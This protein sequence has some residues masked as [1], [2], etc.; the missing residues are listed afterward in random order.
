MTETTPPPSIEPAERQY[1]LSQADAAQRLVEM[2]AAYRAANPTTDLSPQQAEQRLA[3][4][5]KQFREAN[6]EKLSTRDAGIVGHDEPPRPFETTQGG[7]LSLRNTL[8]AIE[9]LRDL[10]IPEVGLQ[11]ILAG[12]WTQEDV[13]W[14]K[15]GKQ[16]LLG[17][18]E[19]RQRVLSGDIDAVRSLAGIS[20]VLASR[21]P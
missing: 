15:A 1:P 20:A 12:D 5:A 10:N 2:T 11:R 14:A 6:R 7:Q 19:L 21:R 18:P 4:M 8:K 3:A 9:D 17:S 16:R 13:D